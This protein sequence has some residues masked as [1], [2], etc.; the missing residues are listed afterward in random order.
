M[1]ICMRPNADIFLTWFFHSDSIVVTGKHPVTNFSHC[2]IIDDL[3]EKARVETDKEKQIQMWKEAGY[4]LMENNIS[5][6]MYV[7]RFV[8]AR[9]ERVKWGYDQKTTLNLYTQISEVTDIE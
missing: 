6:A 5:Y 2:T 7:L 8:F 3:V 1:Y 9:N 4:K